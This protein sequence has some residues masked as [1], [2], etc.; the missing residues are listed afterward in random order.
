MRARARAC[1]CARDSGN[2]WRACA[3]EPNNGGIYVYVVAGLTLMALRGTRARA[4]TQVNRWCAENGTS[5]E[6]NAR[7]HAVRGR[8]SGM[9]VFVCVCLCWRLGCGR[10]LA[11]GWLVRQHLVCTLHTRDDRII[12]TRVRPV[13]MQP[14]P[15]APLVV[16]CTN[17]LILL[18][19]WMKSRACV[20][21]RL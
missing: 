10:L 6:R 13:P 18:C 5:T 4:H 19:D 20:S 17:K 21:V 15:P 9:C 14:P 12:N 2:H 8:A 11:A 3:R 7:L 1:A 16:I